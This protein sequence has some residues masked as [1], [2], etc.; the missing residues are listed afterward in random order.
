MMFHFCVLILQVLE[1]ADVLALGY[2]AFLRLDWVEV[3]CSYNAFAYAVNESYPVDG[4]FI[5]IEVVNTAAF[6]LE[7]VCAFYNSGSVHG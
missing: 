3:I 5:K 2:Q 7:R 4:I 6:V 1:H